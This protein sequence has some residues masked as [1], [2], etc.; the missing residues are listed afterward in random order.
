MTESASHFLC[1][2]CNRRYRWSTAVA[3]KKLRCHCGETIAVPANSPDAA[4]MA[5]SGRAAGLNYEANNSEDSEGIVSSFKA[6]AA[7]PW[8]NLVIPSAYIIAAIFA[9]SIAI[10]N[11]CSSATVALGL[12][13]LLLGSVAV[14]AGGMILFGLIRGRQLEISFISFIVATFKMVA[15]ILF[16]DGAAFTLTNYWVNIGVFTRHMEIGWKLV[17]AFPAIYLAL[18]GVMA[19]AL[20]YTLFNNQKDDFVALGFPVSAGL[21]VI[22]FV[23]IIGTLIGIHVYQ[24]ATYVRPP[25]PPPPPAPINAGP[26][27]LPVTDADAKIMEKIHRGFVVMEGRQWESMR[28]KNDHGVAALVESL[29]NAGAK[30]VYVDMDSSY[31]DGHPSK[32]YVELPDDPGQ[33][34]TCKTAADKFL[35]G[36][37]TLGAPGEYQKF[38]VMPIN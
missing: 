12:W 28:I 20:S 15:I 27:P 38:I 33:Q 4:P 8:R 21:W 35:A 19:F 36:T 11:L 3:G 34:G 24:V 1:R 9:L 37:P 31:A 23:L 17:L 16:V 25:P 18:A 32:V 13:T 7:H 26:P 14:V 2:L 5:A 29:Y 22:H 6:V 30:R 10:S